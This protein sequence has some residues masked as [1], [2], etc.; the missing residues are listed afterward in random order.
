M[1]FT[2]SL[3]LLPMSRLPHLDV[4]TSTRF[5]LTKSKGEMGHS[6]SQSAHVT[7]SLRSLFKLQSTM[8]GMSNVILLKDHAKR[9]QCEGMGKQLFTWV[10]LVFRNAREHFLDVCFSNLCVPILQGKTIHG[11]LANSRNRWSVLLGIYQ[12]R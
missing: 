4:A 7:P 8:Q 1:P 9:E 3:P 6:F 2:F 10:L 11:C 5:L 12:L